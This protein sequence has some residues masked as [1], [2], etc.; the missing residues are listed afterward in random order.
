M[1]L[2]GARWRWMELR[3]G[4][5]TVQKYPQEYKQ[6]GINQIYKRVKYLFELFQN[7]FSKWH[8]FQTNFWISALIEID[9]TGLFRR[10]RSSHRRCFFKKG[11]FKTFAKL[12]RKPLCRSSCINKVA[13]PRPS[14][15]LK[16]R[17]RH[18]CF[19]VRFA[20]FSRTRFLQNTSSGH[21]EAES[22]KKLCSLT[23]LGK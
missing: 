17:L 15:L 7:T 20:K 4:G 9:L 2:G 19:L 5:Y 3:G 18:R 8:L 1:E 21:F 12:T 16:K 11:I 6:M 22:Y 13:A 10:S 23:T 14:T